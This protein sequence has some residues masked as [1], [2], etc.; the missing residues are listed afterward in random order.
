MERI[1]KEKKRRDNSKKKKNG[2]FLFI[3]IQENSTNVLKENFRGLK[4]KI[5]GSIGMNQIV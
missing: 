4:T 1:L 5:V 2:G 3:I